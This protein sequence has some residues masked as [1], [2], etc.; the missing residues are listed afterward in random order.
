MIPG[1]NIVFHHDETPPKIS[2]N[3]EEVHLWKPPVEAREKYS[4]AHAMYILKDKTW[5][6]VVNHG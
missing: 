2:A 4:L 5:Y 3:G 6:P 1:Q